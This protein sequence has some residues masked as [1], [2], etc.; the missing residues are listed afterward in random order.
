LA[1]DA[2]AVGFSAW[3]F[4]QVNLPHRRPADPQLRQ[5][6]QRRLGTAVLGVQAGLAR[7]KRSGG[8]FR[9]LEVPAGGLPRL[10]LAHLCTAGIRSGSPEIELPDTQAGML[11]ALFPGDLEGLPV[12]RRWAFGGTEYRRFRRRFLEISTARIYVGL[13]HQPDIDYTLTKERAIWWDDSGTAEGGLPFPCHVRLADHFWRELQKAPVPF[14]QRTFTS[15]AGSTV[16]Q[17]VY[18]WLA[19]RLPRLEEPTLI[20]WAAIKEQFGPEYKRERAFRERFAKP[21]REA[22]FAYPDAKVEVRDE[23][24]ILRPSPPHVAPRP[25]L[26]ARRRVSGQPSTA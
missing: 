14:D 1:L 17:D 21:L 13:D 7:D 25:R 12:A 26:S 16:A 6:W 20:S 24:L 8:T 9:M 18:L 5:F 15:L 11:S 23:G 10:V 3:V 19:F 2:N 4:T 22:L